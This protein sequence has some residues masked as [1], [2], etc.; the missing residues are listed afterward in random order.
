VKNLLEGQ[1]YDVKLLE[2]LNVNRRAIVGELV[3]LANVTR[4]QDLVLIYFAGHGVRRVVGQREHSYWLMYDASIALMDADAIRLSHLLDYVDDIRAKRKVLVLDHCHA[5]RIEARR[6]LGDGSRDATAQPGITRNLFSLDDFSNEVRDSTQQGL[7]IIGAANAEAYE[8]DEL[9]HG[10]FTYVLLDALRTTKA[11]KDR[12]GQIDVMEVSSYMSRGLTE[13]IDMLKLTRPDLRI[14]QTPISFVNVS[15]SGA[16]WRLVDV[17]A[18]EAGLKEVIVNM[19]LQGGLPSRIGIQASTAVTSWE[20][21]K[22]AGIQ[23]SPRDDRIVKT[24]IEIRDIG[25]G[26]SWEAKAQYFESIVNA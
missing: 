14:D 20:Q 7:V 9:K 5:G 12:N 25:N 11:D 1:H 21:A 22:Q 2:D 8:F 23:P 18:A 3:R 19:G 15:G 26:Q 24:L 6:V 17:A 13:T 4:E 10:L 16:P